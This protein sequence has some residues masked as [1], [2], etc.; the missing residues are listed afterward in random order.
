MTLF[1]FQFVRANIKPTLNSNE[2]IQL[3]CTLSCRTV[4]D[5]NNIDVLYQL[6][7]TPLIY[8]EKFSKYIQT[9]N[10]NSADYNCYK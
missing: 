2:K 4:I 7:M 8:F 9:Q 1:H 10:A 6:T 3:Y 5:R